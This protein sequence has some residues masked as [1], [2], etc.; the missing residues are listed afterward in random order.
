HHE[1]VSIGRRRSRALE[2]IEVTIEKDREGPEHG[3]GFLLSEQ[4]AN[5]RSRPLRILMAAGGTGGHI[6]PAL[7]VAEELRERWEN[8]RRERGEPVRA[9]GVIQF[10]GTARG[11]EARLIP[12]AGFPLRTVAAAG[13]VGIA[14]WKK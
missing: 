12:A 8:E 13:L 10:L 11:L 5:E 1:S 6:F 14:G 7:A 9:G 4:P 2:V 3:R